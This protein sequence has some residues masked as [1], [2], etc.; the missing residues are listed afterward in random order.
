MLF[1]FALLATAVAAL[2]SMVLLNGEHWIGVID[3]ALHHGWDTELVALLVPRCNP[4]NVVPLATMLL[5][6][7]LLFLTRGKV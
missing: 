7:T 3:I 6:F 4:L 5:C 2:L 1:R